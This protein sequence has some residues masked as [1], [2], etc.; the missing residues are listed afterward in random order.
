MVRAFFVAIFCL[1]W[2]CSY[3]SNDVCYPFYCADSVADAAVV[4]LLN[5]RP[6]RNKEYTLTGAAPIRDRDV[7][8]LLSKFMGEE[9][10][11]VEL[12]YHDFKSYML[13]SG[14]PFWLVKDSAEFERIKASGVDELATSYTDDLEKLTGKKPETFGD[15]LNNKEAMTSAWS[16]PTTK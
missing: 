7:C 4:V 12:G 2:K 13:K 14:H 1:P 15:Y 3:Y 9:I 5:L 11:H 8:R 10:Q 6:H 16:W